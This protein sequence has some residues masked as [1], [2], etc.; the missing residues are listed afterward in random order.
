MPYSILTRT[1][2]ILGTPSFMP[3]EQAAGKVRDIGPA[4]D[5]YSIGATLYCLLTGQP[6]F[7]GSS[8]LETLNM[9]L[10]EP[11]KEPRSYVPSIPRDL[12][13]ICLKCL[14]K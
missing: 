2:L 9:V 12:Q 7:Q 4:S 11:P 14:E 6:A 1:G 13:T 10:K 8:P 5:V 3:P